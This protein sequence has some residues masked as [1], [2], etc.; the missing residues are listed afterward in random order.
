[1]WGA[2]GEDGDAQ[3]V[4]AWLWNE[5]GGVDAH[6]AEHADATLLMAATMRGQEAMVRMLLRRGASVNLQDSI[7]ATAL[8]AAAGLGHTT[9]VQVLLDAK[10]DASLQAVNG[11]TALMFAEQEKYTAIAQLLRQHAPGGR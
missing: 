9:I 7:G 3:V 10:A 5:G 2:A 1:M 11:I 8:M 6:C 4:A